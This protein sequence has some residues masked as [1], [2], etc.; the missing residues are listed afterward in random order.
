MDCSQRH[1]HGNNDHNKKKKA[2]AA[3]LD[4]LTKKNIEGEVEKW[5]KK[6]TKKNN[7]E[8]RKERRL[9]EKKKRNTLKYKFL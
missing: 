7:D 4:A 9:E 5:Q 1:Q 8:K 3:K 6:E 2:N